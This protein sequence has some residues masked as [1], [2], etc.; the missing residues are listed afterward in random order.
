MYFDCVLT[1]FI[2][3]A[4]QQGALLWLINNI[5]ILFWNLT[6]DV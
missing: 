4:K 3:Y 1:L 2:R 6:I 5:F